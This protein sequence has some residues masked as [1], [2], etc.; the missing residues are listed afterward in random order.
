VRPGGRRATGAIGGSEQR[1]GGG[2]AET[3]GV[4]LHR[5]WARPGGDR[6]SVGGQG[7]RTSPGGDRGTAG[8][9]GACTGGG[10]RVREQSSTGGG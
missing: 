10:R 7:E 8:G 6:G 3:M 4:R 1:P 2:R 5:R 9:R